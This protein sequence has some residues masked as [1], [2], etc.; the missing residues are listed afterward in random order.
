ML[1]DDRGGIGELYSAGIAE[2]IAYNDPAAV[3][4]R[5]AADR[6]VLARH[7]GATAT[8]ECPGCG[9]WLDGTWCTPPGALCP[10][11][12]DLAERLGV[13]IQEDAN[14]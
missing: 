9:A 12:V 10:E 8:D 13:T 11:L 6:R 7:P 5:V 4:R 3:L 1:V 2:H 14:A